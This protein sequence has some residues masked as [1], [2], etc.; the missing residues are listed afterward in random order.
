[1]IF[2]FHFF[3][4]HNNWTADCLASVLL[5]LICQDTRGRQAEPVCVFFL[6]VC[7]HFCTIFGGLQ[8]LERYYAEKRRCIFA[9][10]H[11][12]STVKSNKS[13]SEKALTVW[14]FFPPPV[15]RGPPSISSP[16]WHALLCSHSLCFYLSWLSLWHST[17][18]K[19]GYNSHPESNQCHHLS[20][21]IARG[22]R[23]HSDWLIPATPINV[24]KQGD[25]F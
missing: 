15:I 25:D 9:L 20:S 12:T 4:I 18:E 17:T 5:L 7:G 16:P 1:M 23:S 6:F 24:K 11:E 19:K 14:R 13:Q 10:L 8:T 3:I 21:L 2:L 22:V